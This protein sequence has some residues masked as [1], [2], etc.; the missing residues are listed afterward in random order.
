MRDSTP[1]ALG[2]MDSVVIVTSQER[3]GGSSGAGHVQ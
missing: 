2:V 1:Q 3:G